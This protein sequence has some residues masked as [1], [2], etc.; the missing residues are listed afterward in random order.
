VL[1]PRLSTRS[2]V[3]R[4]PDPTKIQQDPASS[5]TQLRQKV[6]P[7]IHNSNEVDLDVRCPA[8]IQRRPLDRLV[9]SLVVQLTQATT[10]TTATSNP[11]PNLLPTVTQSSSRC[12]KHH[13]LP[14]DPGYLFVRG[15]K[16]K[17]RATCTFGKQH[18]HHLDDLV[19]PAS[20]H[21]G[22]LR[23]PGLPPSQ[24]TRISST[25]HPQIVL[26]VWSFAFSPPEQPMISP[27]IH[28]LPTD[29]R[30]HKVTNHIFPRKTSGFYQATAPVEPA[31]S[32]LPCGVLASSGQL[33][34]GGTWSVIVEL[35]NCTDDSRC[36]GLTG[37]AI[38]STD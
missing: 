22:R 4:N 29:I 8:L 36:G 30:A 31:T 18:S 33:L 5:P 23:P 26:S 19:R 1:A 35:V 10:A 15:I 24:P 25:F 37:D 27:I 28:S 38:L 16:F 2:S 34:H 20:M 14:P 12:I 11:T 3:E 21:C 17:P 32:L 7:L 13:H 6:R 9:K